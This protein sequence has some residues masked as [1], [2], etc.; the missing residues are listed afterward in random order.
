M[1]HNKQDCSNFVFGGLFSS[2]IDAHK[3]LSN[4]AYNRKAGNEG[5]TPIKIKGDLGTIKKDTS[6]ICGVQ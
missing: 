5:I 4:L 1:D 6:S 2:Q 3:Q